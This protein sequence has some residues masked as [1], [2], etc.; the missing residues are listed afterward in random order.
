MRTSRTTS[1]IESK[2]LALSRYSRVGLSGVWVIKKFSRKASSASTLFTHNSKDH[3]N[4][5]SPEKTRRN[6]SSERRSPQLR[7]SFPI[8]AKAW[9]HQLWRSYR[10][11]RDHAHRVG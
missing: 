8:L 1:F 4:A 3:E 5:I 9:L 11:N 10:T 2:D 6:R 7:R